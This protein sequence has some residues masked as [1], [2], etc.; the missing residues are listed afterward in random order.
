[1]Y[2]TCLYKINHILLPVINYLDIKKNAVLASIDLL[3][4]SYLTVV[5]KKKS[6][7]GK[8]IITIM[9][10]TVVELS[11]SLVYLNLSLFL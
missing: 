6:L 5:P 9:N 11:I 10:N 1:M 2:Y 7:S 3:K 4:T 8:G